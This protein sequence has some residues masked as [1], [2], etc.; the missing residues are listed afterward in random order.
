M[1]GY[2]AI[3]WT[4]EAPASVL[5]L[6][7]ATMDGWRV[8]WAGS[9]A[10]V[11]V[12]DPG[13]AIR[14]LP[15]ARGLVL[16]DLNRT[17]LRGQ[18]GDEVESLVISS[19]APIER[20]VGDLLS[21][22]WG[23]YVA[24]IRETQGGWAVLR[25]P[26]GALEA[27]TWSR[28]SVRITA[29]HLPAWMPPD[30]WPLDLAIDWSGVAA[31]VRASA[32]IGARSGLIGLRPITPGAALRGSGVEQ[33]A[34]SPAA[35]AQ[36]APP[37]A[38]DAA[39]RDLV[40]GCVRQLVSDEP[41]LAEI[42]GGLDS[43]IIAASLCGQVRDRVLE[44]TNYFVEGRRGDERAYARD[45][46][47]HLGFPLTEIRK[48][49]FAVTEA[50]LA[51]SA[52][53]LRPGL[54]AKDAAR[55]EEAA[56][57]ALALGARR[58]VTGQGGDMVFFA[59]PTPLLVVDRM[60]ASGRLA[61]ASPYTLNIARWTHRAIWTTPGRR[62]RDELERHNRPVRDH[63][64]MI[65][66]EE[67]P[68]AKQLQIATLAHKL[69]IHVEGL[70]GRAAEVVHPLLAQ[71]ILELCLSL[72]TPTLTEGGRD[73]GLAR[74]VFADRL[75]ASVQSRRSKGDLGAY[76]GQVA[77]ASLPMLRDY[78]LDGELVRAGLLDRAALE[79]MLTRD[80]MIWRGDFSGVMSFAVVE[81]WVRHW[82]GRI[83]AA[84]TSGGGA[85]DSAGRVAP[86]QAITRA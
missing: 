44:W 11:L 56:G 69:T 3:C 22:F 7:E 33:Q 47:A 10:M 82:S 71:P 13:L 53:G 25:D 37:V 39:L 84:R 51:R 41:V 54:S 83:A 28:D 45:V 79:T 43:A 80:H 36:A 60:Y 76:Y 74:R 30:L 64:W 15:G 85:G 26:S 59:T 24:L 48:P 40:D 32:A 23:R 5:A 9:D 72:P 35:A 14:T 67:L 38:P 58:I 18:V 21:R 63:P 65:G 57:R 66:V 27:M 75:P 78:L 81:A 50:M 16:G 42:S 29:S 70:R 2:V 52:D 1:P 20:V 49:D 8:G 77:A 31:W 73:R 4:G 62:W 6:R 86:S 61:W 12:R 34:W 17:S 68:P 19:A 46:A 55:D